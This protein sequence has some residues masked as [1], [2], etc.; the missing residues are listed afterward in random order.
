MPPG[1]LRRMAD[2]LSHRGPDGDGY[3][4]RGVGLASR[5]LSIVDLADGRQPIANEDGSVVT[6]FNGELFDHRSLR[7]ALEAKGHR[8][9][10]HCDTEVIPHLWEDHQDQ[11]F[12]RLQGQFAFALF[13]QS[14]RRVILARDRFGI[15]PLYWSR[16]KSSDGEW[17]LFASEIKAMLASGMVRARPDLRGIDQVFHFFAVPGPATCFEGV[18]ALQ[19]GHYLNIDLGDADAVRVDERIYWAMDFP[20]EGEEEDG[21]SAGHAV[22]GFERVLLDA[23]ERRLR[24]DVPVVSY[25]SGGIDSSIVA[26]MAAKI[27]GEP[28]PA[29]TVQVSSPRF[30]ESDKAAIVSRHIGARPVVVRVGSR[31][32]CAPIRRSFARPKHRSSIPLRLRRYC[33]LERYIARGSRLPSRVRDPMSGSPVTRGTRCIAWSVCRMRSR[34]C[35]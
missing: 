27:R 26:A 23:V 31:T 35:I 12:A 30:D 17:L 10:T 19:P 8:F 9:A 32:S 24:A 2:A 6:V 1:I 34:A 18:Q 29:F 13:D 21:A 25:L 5:R 28:T 15:I 11:I 22:D 7:H 16:Q 3:F 33:S 14:R 20:A 4:E